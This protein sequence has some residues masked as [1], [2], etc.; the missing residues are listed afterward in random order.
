[1]LAIRFVLEHNAHATSFTHAI[2]TPRTSLE[3]QEGVAKAEEYIH[4]LKRMRH[5]DFYFILGHECTH[6]HFMNYVYSIEL[7]RPYSSP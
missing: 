4:T 1:M 3:G 7:E 5:L 6:P 2:Y